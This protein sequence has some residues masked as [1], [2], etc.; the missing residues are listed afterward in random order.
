MLR[1]LDEIRLQALRREQARQDVE[2]AL[3]RRPAP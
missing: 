2:A 3:A 1:D